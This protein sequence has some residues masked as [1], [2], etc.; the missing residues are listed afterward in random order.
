MPRA[1]APKANTTVWLTAQEAADYVQ[2]H[3]N[4][5]CLAAKLGELKGYQNKPHSRWS[6]TTEDLDIWIRRGIPT[7]VAWPTDQ[8][9]WLTSDEAAAYA[10]SSRNTI[11]L[12]AEAGRLIGYQRKFKSNWSFLHKDIDSWI[13]QN[14]TLRTTSDPRRWL[15]VAEAAE[16]ARCS[17]N[18]LT[19]ALQTHELRGFQ[20][21]PRYGRW[22]TD[23][24]DVKMWVSGGEQTSGVFITPAEAAVR[25]DC[26]RE[27]V[28]KALWA[29]RLR[30]FQQGTLS[31]PLTYGSRRR[32]L[33][34]EVDFETWL[35]NRTPNA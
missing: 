5:V 24:E 1:K 13:S 7:G 28:Y 34:D 17:K 9:S 26:V 15:V 12:A 30:G 29:S 10:R 32:W 8:S 18:Q 3:R 21:K 22:I 35:K 19:I 20:H 11:T 2:R 6:F 23:Y 33:I 16:I 31:F 27:D 4:T 25:A 14:S